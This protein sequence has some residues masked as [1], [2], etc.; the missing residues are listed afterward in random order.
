[1]QHVTMQN[2]VVFQF[3]F[4]KTATFC[5]V[6][7]FSPCKCSNVVF[8]GTQ[9]VTMQNVVVFQKV[10]NNWKSGGQERFKWCLHKRYRSP[11]MSVDDPDAEADSI[12]GSMN[13]TIHFTIHFTFL[14]FTSLCFTLL[15]FTLLCFALLHRLYG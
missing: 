5:M 12:Q 4:W 1:M 14:H 9:N 13:F 7:F 3:F 6:T 10:G 2:V 15:Y 8:S 11:M